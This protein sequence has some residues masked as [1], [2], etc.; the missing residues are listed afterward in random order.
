MSH[1]KLSVVMPVYNAEAHLEE[2]IQSYLG[3]T[4]RD[5]EL[6]C[7]DDGSTDSSLAILSAYQ[8]KDSRI[9]IF[10]QANRG[11]G[12]ARNRALSKAQGRYVAFLDA[13]DLYPDAH[14]LASL[15]DLAEKHHVSAA[16]G[17][18]LFLDK[19]GIREAVEGKN[20][21][22]FTQEGLISYRDLQQAYYYQRFIYSREMLVGAQITFPPYRRFQD[23]VFFVRAMLAAEKIAVTDKPV[24]VYRK[25]NKFA[26][27]SDA[28]IADMLK[29]YLDVAALAHEH[30]LE[31]LGAFL[32]ARLAQGGAIREMVEKSIRHGN[33]S[34]Q[35]SLDA[36]QEFLAPY[37]DEQVQK[38]PS[39]TQRISAKLRRLLG[40]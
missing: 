16:G 3:Q 27:L 10:A 31:K 30:D 20:D 23:V 39:I 8:G 32:T 5:S 7:V 13:D 12:H 34:A 36:L 29:G 18:L 6:I 24:Y 19:S 4:L 38:R 11:A 37:R 9:K 33:T 26:E 25:S 22:G 17:S 40:R 14:A 2:S 21:Y 28:Q 35:E 1:I 15:Y